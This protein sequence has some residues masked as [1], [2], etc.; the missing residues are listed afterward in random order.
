MRLLNLKK[1]LAPAALASGVSLVAHAQAPPTISIPLELI[2]ASQATPFP[3]QWRL[4]INVGINA[5]PTRSYLFDTGSSLFNAAYTQS[6]WPGINPPTGGTVPNSTVP[7]GSGVIYCY[8]SSD[9]S[10]CRGYQ[11]N[12]V[13][14]TSLQFYTAQS[15]PGGQTI[16]AA[17]NA[18]PGFQVNALYNQLTNGQPTSI[19]GTTTPVEQGG[20][21]GVFGAGAFTTHPDSNPNYTTGG[22]L[23]QA[24][25]AGATQGYVVAANGQVNPVTNGPKNPPQQVNGQNVLLGGNPTAQAVTTCSPCVMLGLTPELIGQFAVVQPVSGSV[26]TGTIPWATSG[27]GLFPNPYGGPTGNNATAEMGIKLNVTLTAG[28]STLSS[29]ASGLLDTGTGGNTLTTL[30]QNQP[31]FSGSESVREGVTLGV[32]GLNVD[33]SPIPGVTQSTATL[34][35]YDPSSA[36]NYT[37]QFD[38]HAGG[39]TNTIGLGFFLQNSVLFDLDNKA[40]GYTNYFVTNTDMSTAGGPLIV[41][42]SNLPLGLAGVIS[43]TGGVTIQEGGNV[44]LSAANTYTGATSITAGG[45]LLVSGKG[46]I[47][48]SSSVVN[49]GTFDISRAW[50]PVAIEALSGYGKVNLGSQN[51]TIANGSTGTFYGII[52]DGGSYPGTGGSLTIAGGS[53]ALAG[54]NTYTGLTAISAGARLYLGPTASIAS[55]SGLANDGVFDMSYAIQPVF[56][57]NIYGAGQMNLGKEKLTV[58]NASGHYSGVIAD[59]GGSGGAGASLALTG[60]MLALTNANTYSGG[61]SVSGGATLGIAADGSLGNATGGL[62]LNDGTL[63]AMGTIASARAVT[64]GAGG[65]T[66]DTNGFGIAF[67]NA[68]S[69]PGSLTKTGAGVLTLDGANTFTGGAV[70]SQGTLALTGSMTGSL[71]IL[72]GATF[73]STGGWSLAPG[74]VFNNAGTFQSLGGAP[75]VNRGT[76][77]DNGTLM[78][79]LVNAGTLGG[80]GTIFGSVTNNGIASPGN[81]IGTL[82]VVG[83]YTQAAGSS[84]QVETNAAGQADRINVTGA[85][86]TATIAGGTVTLTAATGVYAPS[87]TYTIL[88]ATGGV[89]GTFAN[90]NSLFSFLQPSLSY[91][92]SNV[93]LTLKPGG[94][95]AGAATANQAAVGRVLDQSVAG[96]SG[97]LATVIGTMAT[98]TLA[99]G[100]AAMNAISGQNYSGFGTANLGGGLLFM[101]SLGQQMG[102]ARG[103]FGG[104]TRVAVGQACEASLAE[105]CDG[106]A[107]PWSL[108]GSALGGTG[109]VAGTANAGTLTYNAGGFATGVDYRFDP[110]FLAGIGVGFSSGNQWASGF[111]GQG[112]T[113][114]YQASLY[115]SF[116]QG[117]FYLDGMAGYGYNDNQMTRQI[118][119]PNLAART[120]QGRTGANQFL[121]QAEAGY[122]I[123]LHEPTALSIT[124]FARFQGMTN[125]QN[126]FTESGA[127]ALNLNVAAQTTGSARSVLGAEFA[128]AFGA[129]GREKLAVQ[130]RLGWAHEYADTARPVTAAFAGAPGATFTVFGA[131]PQRDTATFSLAA[132]TTVAQGVSLFARYDGE[133]GNGI[134]SHALNGGLRMTW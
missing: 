65:G 101:N 24:I 124:P 3:A 30:F 7:N 107:S 32:T 97:D 118:V 57:Q 114:S 15:S 11:G 9:L 33:G 96:S 2:Y 130:M 43:G 72:S 119:L 94:F 52:A 5:G 53:Q 111:S 126:G 42:G 75:L 61:T 92:A 100:Q 28:S 70:V 4:G 67:S 66:I 113:N 17:L 128:G 91:D 19:V 48:S 68:L 120:A 76:L 117:A 1:S 14:A 46:S 39:T 71:A 104:G 85:P 105:A 121:G 27:P 78:S 60:G 115:A 108:W 102:L 129:E 44:Q 122:R 62:T 51:L 47:A 40:I 123:G 16:A 29:T 36:V 132:G 21:F 133:V 18:S 82:N 31:G 103:G 12:I 116:T 22:V 84:Y 10:T 45:K 89:T 86:G 93:F 23:G 26:P 127:D 98:Y 55:S 80:N 25:V 56:L 134:S 88:N 8:G 73:T 79:N 59:G 49:D 34:G 109:R 63:A 37:A 50:A 64:L 13:Q 69:G 41:G 81:S 38:Q 106:A 35:S 131:S 90:A 77:I 83:A 54:V 20:F 112:T 6:Y 110:H 95:G 99:Q 58:T 74:T 87:T 125:S